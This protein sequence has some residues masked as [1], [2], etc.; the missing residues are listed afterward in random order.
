M[1][2]SRA[3]LVVEPAWIGRLK[4]FRPEGEGRV[5]FVSNSPAMGVCYRQPA[6]EYREHMDREGDPVPSDSGVAPE[7]RDP[8]VRPG[9][10]GPR[11]SPWA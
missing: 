8:S 2:Q 7:G 1:T 5:P 3:G 11:S 6:G 4:M 10:S 9:G